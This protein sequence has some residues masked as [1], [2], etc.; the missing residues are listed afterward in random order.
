MHYENGRNL[1]GIMVDQIFM[2]RPNNDLLLVV[3]S[4][5]FL[6]VCMNHLKLQFI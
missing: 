5:W 6:F 4:G 3:L 1:G 2:R